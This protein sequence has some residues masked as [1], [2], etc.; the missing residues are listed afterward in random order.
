MIT[1]IYTLLTLWFVLVA[2]N[3]AFKFKAEW[4]ARVEWSDNL[5]HLPME[6]VIDANGNNIGH[7]DRHGEF[8]YR[9]KPQFRLMVK[10]R[11]YK[12]NSGWHDS[13]FTHYDG[14]KDSCGPEI[15]KG[16]CY[17][18]VGGTK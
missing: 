18:L 10:P 16:K 13:E 6:K 5:M 1:T 3:C 9:I 14:R 7:T 11:F 2:I 4:G 15:I 8:T 12:T 17:F